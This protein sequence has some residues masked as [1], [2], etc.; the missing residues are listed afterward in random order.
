MRWLL[1]FLSRFRDGRL[2][3]GNSLRAVFKTGRPSTKWAPVLDGDLLHAFLAGCD[4]RKQL[5]QLERDIR[6]RFNLYQSCSEYFHNSRTKARIAAIKAVQGDPRVASACIFHGDGRVR[7]AALNALDGPIELPAVAY[8]MLLRL[9]DWSVQVRRAADAAMRRCF[10]VTRAEILLDPIWLILPRATSW[11]RW[12]TD[13]SEQVY[14]GEIGV[15]AAS[16]A[17]YSALIAFLAGQPD[18]IEAVVRRLCGADRS[19]NIGVFRACCRSASL[20]A[21]LMR[22]ARGAKAPHLRALALDALVEGRV[23]WPLGT[24]RKVWTNKVMGEFRYV[25]DYGRRSLTLP[26]AP[27]LA[28]LLGD[29]L[30][31]PVPMVRRTALDLLIAR[32]TDPRLS[33]V[34]AA[35][36]A[37]FAADPGPGLRARRDYLAERMAGQAGAQ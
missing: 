21:H 25:H 13:V 12:G 17:A 9:N 2:L 6:Y 23:I 34:I 15:S 30:A 11:G 18:L 4:G 5:A 31:D 37:R 22:I 29:A 10:P 8:G 35:A 16:E 7:E 26:E 20:D 24:R 3:P 28:Q 19:N 33:P 27:D 14:S 36:L 32:R 1:A